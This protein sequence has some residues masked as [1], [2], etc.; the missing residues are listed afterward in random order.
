MGEL[1]QQQSHWNCPP[2]RECSLYPASS[3][4]AAGPSARPNST[5]ALRVIY[6][7]MCIF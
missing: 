2:H 1:E 6:H 4:T 7:P 5:L 3:H